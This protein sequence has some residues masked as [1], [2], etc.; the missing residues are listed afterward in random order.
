MD[1]T[2][3]A[4]AGFGENAKVVAV[5]AVIIVVMLVGT[6]VGA[7]FGPDDPAA[8]TPDAT[9]SC[10]GIEEI[11]VYFD[12]DKDSPWARVRN[13]DFVGFLASMM[14]G[15]DNDA[16]PPCSTTVRLVAEHPAHKQADFDAAAPTPEERYENLQGQVTENGN[17]TCTYRD[18][19]GVAHQSACGWV[20]LSE[21]S[22]AQVEEEVQVAAAAVATAPE[23]VSGVS[24]ERM[25]ELWVEDLEE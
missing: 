16:L 1:N 14:L 2:T 4:K 6:I 13:T 23:Q 7:I 18:T 3:P 20:S 19:D 22:R 9:P 5:C 8:P 24:D 10:D 17:G 12:A 21:E 25:R 15:A 11:N